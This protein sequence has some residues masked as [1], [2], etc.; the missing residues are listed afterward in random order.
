M[1]KLASGEREKARELTRRLQAAGIPVVDVEQVK[2]P[3]LLITQDFDA[4]ESMAFDVNTGTGLIVPLKITCDVSY[5]VFQGFH[6][7]LDR[8]QGTYFRALEEND[9]NDWPHYDF[10]GRSNLKFDRGETINRFIASQRQFR[11]GEMLAGLLL[12]FSYGRMP[13][14]IV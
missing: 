14:D 13:E 9:G 4:Y 6:I 7:A 12:A 11:R 8:W 1:A 10:Y 3:D 2:G 5:F